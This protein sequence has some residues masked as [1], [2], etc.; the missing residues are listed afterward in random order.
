MARASWRYQTNDFPEVH[1][2]RHCSFPHLNHLTPTQLSLS[3][4]LSPQSNAQWFEQTLDHFDTQNN[5]T[6]KQRFQVN[7]TFFNPSVP[8]VFLLLGGEGPA[9]GAWLAAPTAMLRPA[10]RLSSNAR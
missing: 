10:A 7:D 6:F 3:L 2:P 8:R 4:S 5:A 1:L 9:N